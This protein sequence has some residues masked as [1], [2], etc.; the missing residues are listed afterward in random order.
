MEKQ[1]V[2][3]NLPEALKVVKEMNLGRD[4]EWGGEYRDAARAS[5]ARS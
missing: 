4:D 2:I 3:K 1:T 5:I